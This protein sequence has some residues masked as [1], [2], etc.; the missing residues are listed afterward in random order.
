MHMSTRQNIL[1]R[2]QQPVVNPVVRTAWGLRVPLPGDALLETTGQRTGVRDIKA[3]PRV[4]PD[5]K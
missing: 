5:D 1:G 3:N 2:L 4:D